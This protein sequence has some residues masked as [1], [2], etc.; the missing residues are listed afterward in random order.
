MQ[1]SDDYFTDDLVLNDEDLAALDE[2]EQKFALALT[3][4]RPT[5]SPPTKRQKTEDGWKPGRGN[6]NLDTRE[7]LED[8]PEISVQ[9]DG[10]YGIGSSR[11]GNAR[12][13]SIQEPR[14]IPPPSRLSRGNSR[15]SS[16]SSSPILHSARVESI[17]LPLAIRSSSSGPRQSIH[18]PHEQYS[19]TSSSRLR[20]AQV[21]SQQPAPPAFQHVTT[22]GVQSPQQNDAEIEA[23]RRQIKEVRLLYL[24]R[25]YISYPL[26]ILSSFTKRT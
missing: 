24:T 18:I 1:D 11:H 19:S 12:L 9:G 7:D 26:I 17:P 23:L 21:Q 16:G 5:A 15:V 14:V 13:L 4:M 2:E 6:H 8:L 25:W 20:V 10:T 22:P 3:Q